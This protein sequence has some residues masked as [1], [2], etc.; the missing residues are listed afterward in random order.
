MANGSAMAFSGSGESNLRS[1]LL[2]T[3]GISGTSISV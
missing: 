2:L 1:G 3:T